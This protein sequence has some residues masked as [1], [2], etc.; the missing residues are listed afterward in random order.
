MINGNEIDIYVDGSSYSKPRRCGIGI[1]I[2][3]INDDGNEEVEDIVP[4]GYKGGTN[5]Q[6]EL[7]ACV[8]ALKERY[9][10]MLWMKVKYPFKFLASQRP[11]LDDLIPR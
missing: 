7:Q 1:R 10:Q 3:T 2:I 8:E 5:Q 11:V 4:Q 6:M 9:C